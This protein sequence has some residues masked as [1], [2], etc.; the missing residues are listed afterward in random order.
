MNY[1]TLGKTKIS[2]KVTQSKRRTTEI[3]VDKSGVQ[4]LTSI[5]KNNKTIHNAIQNHSKWI[6]KK[7]LQLQDYTPTKITFKDKSKLSYLGK[8]H[9]LE[10]TKSSSNSFVFKDGIFYASL[11]N[12]TM[13]NVKKLY[14]DWE[15]QKAKSLLKKRIK[16]H[17]K[18]T[19]L[20]PSKIIVKTLK[21]KWGG[22]SKKRTL[23][24]NQKLIR[25]PGKIIDY[26]IIHELCH[27]KIPNHGHSF[28]NMVSGKMSDYERRKVWLRENQYL[29]E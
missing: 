9:L 5:T 27:L 10:I 2:Y 11:K 1:I 16:R 28:W 8:W 29:L 19:K 13:N 22:V 18:S 23:T 12:P 6:F 3:L 15:Q 24:I 17:S 25:A 20:V 26:V 7:Q 14:L 4:V 21:T